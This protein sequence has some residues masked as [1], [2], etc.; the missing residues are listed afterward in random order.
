[1]DMKEGM[2]KILMLAMII[3]CVFWASAV[4]ESRVKSAT[5]KACRNEG[6]S[7]RKNHAREA[8]Q[9][10]HTKQPC[11]EIHAKA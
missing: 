2:L 7:R 4:A 5:G 6:L 10:H 8:H 11:R 1:M 9:R 3:G